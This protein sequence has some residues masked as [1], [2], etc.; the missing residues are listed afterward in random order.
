MSDTTTNWVTFL[1]SNDR[2]GG[3]SAVRTSGLKELIWKVTLPESVRSSPVLRDGVLYVTCRNGILYALDS[4]GGKERW[5]YQAADALRSTPSLSGNLVLFGGDDGAVY[6]VDRTAGRL[7]W[8]TEIGGQVWTSPVV[9]GDTVFSGSTNGAFV[10]MDRVTGKVR[11]RREFDGQILSTAYATEKMVYFGCGNGKL[12]A[13]DPATGKDV[14][15]H[16]TDDGIAGA[17]VVIDNLVVVGSEDLHRPRGRR[18]VGQAALEVRDGIRHPV[19]ARRFRRQGLHRRQ[20]RLPLRVDAGRRESR[21]E[22]EAAAHAHRGAGRGRGHGLDSGLL[23]D[24]AG[25]RHQHGRRAVAHEPRRLAAVD[26]DRH[27][28]SGLSRDVSRCRL[29]GAVGSAS[30]AR[31]VR[32]KHRRDVDDR[33]ACAAPSRRPRLAPITPVTLQR[34]VMGTMF[35]IVIYHPSQADGARAAER[36]MREIERLDRVL[37]HFKDD[38]DLSRLNREGGRGFV[39][40]DASLYD[41]VNQSIE[42]SRRTGGTFDITIAPLLRT[43]KQAY[44]DG[45]RPSDDEIAAARTCV[46]SDK[47]ALEAPNRIHFRSTLPRDRSRRHRQGLRRRSRAGAVEGGRRQ[48][49]DDQRGRQLDRH[50]RHAAWT[51]R[52][53]RAHRREGP[54]QRHAAAARH[55]DVDVAAESASVRDDRRQLR[56]NPRSAHRRAG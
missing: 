46:G 11:W 44:A 3:T 33:G 49:G 42:W 18:R 45:R 13:L 50:D 40:V 31:R 12:Y 9:F 1:A 7:S 5:T 19:D 23:R 32:G 26:A 41:I 10:A 35:D 52:M 15:T 53:G 38:S 16:E 48:L 47:I 17:P 34:Y 8:K 39:A 55:V 29:C 28:G 27:R 43:W 24:D 6:A 14:W 30:R 51:G 54:G 37:S 22:V 4:R 36:A 56:R 2:R 21:V 25:V 20:G